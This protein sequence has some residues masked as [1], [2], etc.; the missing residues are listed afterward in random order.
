VE[1]SQSLCQGIGGFSF[2]EHVKILFI[3]KLK[4]KIHIDQL[5][6][7]VQPFAQMDLYLGLQ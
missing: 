2:D 5:Y 7:V 3:F 6:T 1:K 4:F